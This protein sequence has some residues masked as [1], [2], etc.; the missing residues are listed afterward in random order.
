MEPLS[1]STVS[2]TLTRYSLEIAQLSET[3]PRRQR[4]SGLNFA[5]LPG[6]QFTAFA[7][8][9]PAT[10]ALNGSSGAERKEASRSKWQSPNDVCSDAVQPVPSRFQNSEEKTPTE[11]LP[12]FSPTSS[13]ASSS[14][15]NVVSSDVHLD[16]RF[17]RR[18]VY[19]REVC[20]S[21]DELDWGDPPPSIACRRSAFASDGGAVRVASED[22]GDGSSLP[23][24]RGRRCKSTVIMNNPSVATSFIHT[25]KPMVASIEQLQGIVRVGT[26]IHRTRYLRLINCTLICHRRCRTGTLVWTEVITERTSIRLDIS[27]AKLVLSFSGGRSVRLKFLNASLAAHWAGEMR[28]VKERKEPSAPASL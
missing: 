27:A 5:T 9:S 21:T 1:T 8:P 22:E 7:N 14:R 24:L 16:R 15:K 23:Y 25:R 2:A 18:A 20:Q 19:R 11:H 12:S 26:L 17:R 10:H 4:T 13:Y 3:V 28:A 6:A